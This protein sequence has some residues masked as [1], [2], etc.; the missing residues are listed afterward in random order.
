[1]AEIVSSAVVQETVSQ[2]LAGLVQK[3]EDK[4]DSNANRN[5]ERLEMAQIRLE[6]A[7]ETSEKWKI[8]DASLLRWRRKL[9]RAAQECDETLHKCKQRI[10][11]DEQMQHEVRNSSLPARIVHATKS[12]V[13]SMLHRNSN[14]LRRSIAQRFEWYADGASEF[15]RFVE[16]GG[17]PRHHMPFNNLVRN[18]FA[19]K[20]LHHRIIGG[21]KN[22]SFQLLLVPFSTEVYG[23]EA[24]LVV[25]QNEGTRTP[26]GNIY[27]S[28]TVQLSEC[29][30]IVGIAIKCLMLFAPHFKCTVEKIK[31]EI[32]QLLTEDLSWM[33]SIYSH[34]KE[35]V[36]L[37]TL[38]W[39]RPNPSCCKQ[40]G[41]HEVQRR[42]GSLQDLAG[43]SN[44]WLEPVLK[45]NL[46]CQVPL[47]VYNR[48]K[49]L[50]SEDIISLEDPPYLKS[51]IFF[52]PH[53][54]LKDML[55][56]NRCSEIV[57]IVGEEQHC[58]HTDITL[59]QLEEIILPGAID[60]FHRNAK[61]TAHK[62]IWKSR[63]GT[64]HIQIEKGSVRTRRSFGGASSK[65]KLMKRQ[66][67]EL[68]SWARL[69][70]HLLDLWGVHAPV[71]LRS[72]L[73]DWLQKDKERHQLAAPQF[74]P[75]TSTDV[76]L[77]P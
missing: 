10:L 48:Q 46:Q 8:T 59:E 36:L 14:E 75:E 47:S 27:F 3:Y 51:G 12:F 4:E 70:S 25:I 16:L 29:T 24:S 50:P 21:N 37:G 19:G 56:G 2:V 17:T 77:G 57:A 73:V 34:K 13:S 61:A 58:L 62:I 28:I 9:K 43:L 65:G 45:L 23:T 63:H 11:E 52:T 5:L 6:A 40:H 71:Q 35:H 67:Q 44:D 38:Q 69:I 74:T 76:V 30:D 72:T 39:L 66:D 49:T 20:E 26:E 1:M 55:P 64:A 54:S 53:R 22:P 68:V 32:S 15:M 42:T 31:K 33:P 60:Y 7:L 41:R 18:L